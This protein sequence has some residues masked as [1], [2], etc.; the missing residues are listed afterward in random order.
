MLDDEVKQFSAF[1][2]LGRQESDAVGFPC[3]VELVDVRVIEAS[4]NVHFCDK[5]FIVFDF[6]FLDGFDGD[7]VASLFI[8]GKIDCSISTSTQLLLEEILII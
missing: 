5:A 1:A 2:I 7:I 3:F 6:E 8:F 4:E